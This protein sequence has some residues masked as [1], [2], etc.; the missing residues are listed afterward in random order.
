[1]EAS[2]VDN[3]AELQH[4]LAEEKTRI[5]LVDDEP[6]ILLS[7][8]RLLSSKYEDCLI[9]TASSAEKALQM[10]TTSVVDLVITDFRLPEMDGLELSARIRAR[11]PKTRLILMTAYGTGEMVHSAGDS[12]CVGYLEKPLDIAQLIF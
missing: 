6:N 4:P 1:M 10:L 8:S 7:L 11:S 9:E 2:I 3:A 12:G 5:L